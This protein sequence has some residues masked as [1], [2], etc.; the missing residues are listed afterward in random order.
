MAEPDTAFEAFCAAG[1]WPGLG[2]TTA[3]RLAEARINGPDDVS[4]ETLSKVEGITPKRAERLAKSFALVAPRYAVAELLHRTGLPV[5]GGAAAGGDLGSSAASIL[6]V[7]PWRLLECTSAV[8]PREADRFALAVLDERPEKSD[9]R[10]GRAF[11]VHV[12]ARAARD[13]HTVLPE[14]TVLAALAGLDVPDPSAA[15]EASVDDGVVT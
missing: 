3:G 13:G 6:E 15:I 14:D 12:L 11:T 5:R 9:P 1:L 4:V 8:Q 7:D 2:R 10:R